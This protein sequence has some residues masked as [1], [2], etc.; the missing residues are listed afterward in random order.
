M[1]KIKFKYDV[2]ESPESK[3]EHLILSLQHVFAMFGSTVLVPTL[4]GLDIATSLVSAGIG[5][6]I[7]TQITKKMVPVFIGSSFAY[8]VLLKQL[9]D[10]FGPSGVSTAVIFVGLLYCLF[11]FIISFVGTKWI[12]KTLPPV[13][14]GPLII[15]IGLYL[16]PIAIENAGLNSTLDSYSYTNIIISITSI[17][18]AT[19]ALLLGKKTM[20]IIPIIIGITSGYIMSLIL[21]LVTKTEIVDTSNIFNQPLF[22]IPQFQIPFL[23]FNYEF[24]FSILFAVLPL[25]IVTLSEHIGDHSVSSIM[26]NKDFLKNPGLKK[27]ILGD[28]LASIFA[29]LIGGPVNT[30]YAEN[31]GVIMLT[32]IASI[33]VIRLAAVFAIILAFISPVIGF[34]NS[35]PTPV[36]GGISIILFGMI[37]QNGLRILIDANIDISHPR[38]LILM[39]VIL[40]VGL[41]GGSLSFSINEAQFLFSGTSLAAFI[42]VVLHLILPKKSVAYGIKNKHIN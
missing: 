10:S 37:A 21:E 11:S 20:K 26:L 42:G 40:V 34:I 41:G 16:A 12:D 17:L 18:G 3:I 9:N 29:G 14:I 2:H 15:I 39:S 7:Y 33:S 13:V 28:G 36:M 24:N 5:T 32:R 31:T 22:Q 30:T 8:I 6:L 23:T 35:I 19:L 25:V 38:N 4:I 1:N 27:T